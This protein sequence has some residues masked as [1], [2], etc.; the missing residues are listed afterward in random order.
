MDFRNGAT[1]SA[2]RRDR[3]LSQSD[4]EFPKFLR[5]PET[6]D[7]RLDRKTKQLFEE[8]QRIERRAEELRKVN[9]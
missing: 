7:L 4:R 9:C 1:N 2:S 6:D 3:S 8:W 5:K